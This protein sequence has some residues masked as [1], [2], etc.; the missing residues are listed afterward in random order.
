MTQTALSEAAMLDGLR[1]IRLPAGSAEAVLAD[2]VTAL[3]LGGV[4]A[5]AVLLILRAIAQLRPRQRPPSLQLK[6]QAALAMPPAARRVAL[7]R[8]L[9]DHAPD[10]FA[11]LEPQLYQPGAVTDDTLAAEVRALA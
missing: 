10:R 11:A 3:G 1:D 8:L 4:A 9:R 5:V 6:T 2:V 7:L